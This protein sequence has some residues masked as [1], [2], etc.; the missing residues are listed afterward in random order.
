MR[1][2]YKYYVRASSIFTG[3]LPQVL[4]VRKALDIYNATIKVKKNVAEEN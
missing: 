2:S 3:A 1:T 4:H